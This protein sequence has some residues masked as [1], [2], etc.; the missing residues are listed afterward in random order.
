MKNETK[1][2]VLSVLISTMVFGA[3]MFVF[4]HFV[5]E[6]PFN[7]ALLKA[8]LAALVFSI[9]SGIIRAFLNRKK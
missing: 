5:D 2:L 3:I 6:I 9:I 4:Y 1:A 8:G 7:E